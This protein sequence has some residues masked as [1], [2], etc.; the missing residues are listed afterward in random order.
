MHT[1]LK[2]LHL[3]GAIMFFGSI[4]GHVT[5]GFIPAAKTDPQ[6]ALIARQA[7]DVATTYLTLPGL[8]LLL[9]TGTLMIV[10]G[11]LRI[12][13][14]RWLAVH[15][16]FGLLIAVNAAFV[17]LPTG[18]D[19]LQAASQVAAGDLSM[20]QLHAIE[21]RE[22]AFGAVNVLLCLAMVVIAVVKPGIGKAET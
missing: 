18:Q 3:L 10:K 12:L 8:V 11:R 5:T 20:D 13:R 19:L 16:V 1:L 22:A 14:I 21:G 7:I 6:T 4:L 2:A 15:A 9:V 17:L